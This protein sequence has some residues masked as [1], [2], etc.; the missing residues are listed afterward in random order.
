MPHMVLERAEVKAEA[1]ADVLTL[2]LLF[3]RPGD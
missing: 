1:G 3:E 2:F